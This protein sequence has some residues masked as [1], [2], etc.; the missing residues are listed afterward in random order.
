MSYAN[1]YVGAVALFDASTADTLFLDVLKEPEYERWAAEALVHLART[2]PVEAGIRP[3][4][5]L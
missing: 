5:R 4:K 3:E 2:S 1:W